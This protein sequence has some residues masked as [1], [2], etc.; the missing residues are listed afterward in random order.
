M[1][2][3][4]ADLTTD[5]RALLLEVALKRAPQLVLMLGQPTHVISEGDSA[6]LTEAIG[7]ELVAT[8]MDQDWELSE[9][10]YVLERLLDRVNTVRI[11][12]QG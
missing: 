4:I 6:I 9:R 12:R 1:V 11:H 5:E 8:G 7:D 10:G 3:R 2:L